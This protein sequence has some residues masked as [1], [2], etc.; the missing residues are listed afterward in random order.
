VHVQS[1]C[2]HFLFKR[3]V[4]EIAECCDAGVVDQQIDGTQA[5]DTLDY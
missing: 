2:A 3:G 1:Y 5:D 4:L